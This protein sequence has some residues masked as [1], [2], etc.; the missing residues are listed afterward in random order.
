MFEERPYS[1]KTASEAMD[2]E[3]RAI[4]DG[5]YLP[6]HTCFVQR[7][8]G[9]CGEGSQVAVGDGNYY[10]RSTL[11]LSKKTQHT[12]SSSNDAE[13]TRWHMARHQKRKTRVR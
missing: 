3:A 7:E 9:R 1:E 5:T 8:E 6:A 4:V 2:E 10:K 12:K 11:G 13:R